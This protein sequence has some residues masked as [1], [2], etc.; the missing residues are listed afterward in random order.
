MFPNSSL[1]ASQHVACSRVEHRPRTEVMIM[2]LLVTLTSV[3][4]GV[5]V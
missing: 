1:F 5:F 3:N 4:G 2:Y